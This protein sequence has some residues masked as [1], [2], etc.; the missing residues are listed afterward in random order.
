MKIIVL[1][2]AVAVEVSDVKIATGG[3]AIQYQSQL[4]T[5]NEC[6]E[7]ALEEAIVLKRAHGGEVTVLTMG[8]IKTQNI[9]HL[10]L[11]KGADR[12]VRI[13]AQ[14]QDSQAASIVLAA[15]LRKL[16]YDLILT[17]TQS[18]DTLS[19]IAGISIAERL[20]IPFCFAVTQVEMGGDKSIRV[21][22]ELGGGRSADVKLPLPALL[23]V[24]TGIQRLTYVPPARMLRARQQPVRSLSLGDLGLAEE[25]VVAQGYHFLDVFPPTRTGQ[26]QFLQGS[27]Q[28]V[29]TTLLAKIKE[30]M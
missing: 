28:E 15:A 11:A 18:R 3:K 5:I 20:E 29:A 26:V 25:Q 4:L 12:A 17:G 9:L 14:I 2:K 19:G 1:C 27:A 16:E 8:S 30:V 21:L 6:D 22:K 23:C 13:D 24:Q 10:A 7:Y